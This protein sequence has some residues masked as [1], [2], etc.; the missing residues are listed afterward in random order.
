M[1][2]TNH[3]ETVVGVKSELPY[4]KQE[5]LA[6]EGGICIAGLFLFDVSCL[7]SCVAIRRRVQVLQIS[8]TA[9]N[10]AT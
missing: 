4:S 6:T 5:K 7:S 10:H 1:D 9:D 3:G 8:A 2:T